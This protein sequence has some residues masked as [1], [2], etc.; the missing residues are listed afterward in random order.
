MAADEVVD[1]YQIDALLNAEEKKVRDAVRAFVDKECMP[2]IAEHFDKG[3][4][5]VKLIPELAG[6]GL[7]GVHVDGYGCSESNHT[8]YGLICQEL[9]RCDSGLRAMFSVQ[10]SLVM[11]PI[12]KFG[13]EQQREKWL[14]ELATGNSIGCFVG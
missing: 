8:T 7:F 10:N 12:Y 13:S 9:G 4:F 3:T 11:F 14:P 1:F 5:P 6:L 2:V